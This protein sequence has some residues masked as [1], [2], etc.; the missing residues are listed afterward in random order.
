MDAA[1]PVV[2]M[3]AA[4]VVLEAAM[5]AD[6]RAEV[7]VSVAAGAEVSGGDRW[8]ATGAGTASKAAILA[9]AVSVEEW[10]EA[11]MVAEVTEVGAKEAGAMAEEAMEAATVVVVTVAEETEVEVRAAEEM[12]VVSEGVAVAMEVAV[13][14]GPRA[15]AEARRAGLAVATAATC[16]EGRSRRNRCRID[17]VP[18][19]PRDHCL[20]LRGCPRPRT[21]RFPPE[22]RY[23]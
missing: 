3:V 23:P 6:A 9:A 17:K 12:A 11:E 19:Q 7:G 8:E 20:L 5:T 2:G 22:R 13:R 4:A 21:R 18:R 16:I 10:M 14:A 1:A 15:D